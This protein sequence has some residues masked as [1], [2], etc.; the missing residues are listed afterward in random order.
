MSG[1]DFWRDWKITKF[2]F[3]MLRDSL[4]AFSQSQRFPR[5]M[6]T[7]FSSSRKFLLAYNM[8]VSSANK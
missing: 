5:S 8:L 7:L 1:K 4:L 3:L 6:L 2:E